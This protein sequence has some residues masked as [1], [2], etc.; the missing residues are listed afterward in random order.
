M[1]KLL[2]ALLIISLLSQPILV[3]AQEMK[4]DK[5]VIRI[6]QIFDISEE[7]EDFSVNQQ[8]G[9]E[10]GVFTNYTWSDEKLGY[11]SVRVDNKGNVVSFDRNYPENKNVS[12]GRIK[13]AKE[14]A[15]KQINKIDENILK[16]YEFVDKKSNLDFKSNIAN[17]T[18]QRKF[19]D[20]EVS[21]DTILVVVNLNHKKVIS[22]NRNEKFVNVKDDQFKDPS[23]AIDE[24]QGQ[25]AFKNEIGLKRAYYIKYNRETKSNEAIPVYAV[26]NKN[27]EIDALTGK[28]IKR[29]PVYFVMD[30]AKGEMGSA[31][32]DGGLTPIEKEEL[33]NQKSLKSKDDAVKAAELISTVKGYKLSNYQTYK[34]EDEYYWNLNFTKDDENKNFILDAKTLNLKD[35]SQYNQNRDKSAEIQSEKAINIAKTFIEKVDK[36]AMENIDLKSPILT[37]EKANTIVYYPRI[38]G[39]FYVVENGIEVTV[40]NSTGEVYGYNKNFSKVN[41]NKPGKDIGFE[42]AYETIFKGAN[43]GLM[44]K[45]NEKME[46]KLV[47]D[48]DKANIPYVNMEDGTLINVYRDYDYI[49]EILYP[50]L[51]ESKY[52]KE[53]AELVEFGLGFPESE[54]KPKEEI[55][56]K[57]LIYLLVKFKTGYLKYD[58]EG[59]DQAYETATGY[60]NILSKEE[61]DR[62]GKVSTGTFYRYLLRSLGLQS[63]DTINPAIFDKNLFT[64]IS[65]IDKKDIPYIYGAYGFGLIKT[66]T[67]NPSL[68]INR[69]ETLYN[70]YLIIEQLENFNLAY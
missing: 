38:T 21:N 1:K 45:F 43:F 58:D 19:K 28:A 17:F 59:I 2:I 32:G 6:K 31:A 61:I 69:E 64:D 56:Q 11:I 10:G 8:E 68:N 42:Q 27:L 41:F 24:K 35:F 47:Y 46:N 67:I 22:F 53:I 7:Y 39:D 26:I 34:S 16:K 9:E 23:N 20:I 30:R 3:M 70:L 5:S 52:K 54:L 50:D 37:E 40:N 44:Y 62:D 14:I 65:K 13:E 18:L 33:E 25:E 60:L 36:G 12:R 55:K 63:F 49:Q 57:D 48:F 66:K 15:E 4:E 29:D 51:E